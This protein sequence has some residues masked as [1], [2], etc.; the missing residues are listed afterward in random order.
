MTPLW[1]GPS[2]QAQMSL[3]SILF[4]LVLALGTW[5]SA[6]A[7]RAAF[8]E[9]SQRFR[10]GATV[11]ATGRDSAETRGRLVRV[12]SPSIVMNVDG[13]EREILW[14]EIGW[15]SGVAINYGM[16]RWLARPSWGGPLPEARERAVHRIA[17][18]L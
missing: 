4:F 7:Q 2:T 8:A 11:F 14:T 16:A 6:E 12:S 13:Q 1:D 15:T 5:R 18:R 9:V 3:E 17:R 10:P